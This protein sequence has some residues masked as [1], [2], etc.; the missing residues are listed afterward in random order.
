MTDTLLS[1]S[2]LHC[3]FVYCY[4]HDQGAVAIITHAE[5][6]D[7]FGITH[8]SNDYYDN[9][10]YYEKVFKYVD[11]MCYGNPRGCKGTW[12]CCGKLEYIPQGEV[13]LFQDSVKTN[14]DREGGG[15]TLA[16]FKGELYTS[17][18]QIE[19]YRLPRVV[20]EFLSHRD[21]PYPLSD[22]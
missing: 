22:D 6:L 4:Q 19:D 9:N 20:R 7:T 15:W 10:D 18:E 3:V 11:S 2:H 16:H 13:L 1:D 12:E 5:W 14:F 21:A 8:T 17:K